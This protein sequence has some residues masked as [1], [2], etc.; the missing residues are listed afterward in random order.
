MEK[1]QLKQFVKIYHSQRFRYKYLNTMC[2]PRYDNGSKKVEPFMK[3]KLIITEMDDGSLHRF[4]RRFGSLL[5]NSSIQKMK[6]G[7]VCLSTCNYVFNLVLFSFMQLSL[8]DHG[9]WSGEIV[10]LQW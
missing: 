9:I 5:N 7:M 3:V 2:V 1:S 8:L 6:F 4:I 10:Q